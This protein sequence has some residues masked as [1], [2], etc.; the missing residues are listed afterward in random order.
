MP[1][2]SRDAFLAQVRRVSER[3][4]DREAPVRR[5]IVMPD[6]GFMQSAKLTRIQFDCGLKAV[7]R[8]PPR[9][10]RMKR[11][12]RA[13]RHALNHYRAAM[14]AIQEETL[15]CPPPETE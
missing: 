2:M 13:Y 3:P 4:P 7:P 12:F 6:K 11:E 10:Q 1:M 14:K 5:Y 15:D 8:C 9:I